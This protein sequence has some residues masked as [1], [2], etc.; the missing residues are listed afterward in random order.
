MGGVKKDRG[1]VI[2]MLADRG[3]IE[4]T[5]PSQPTVCVISIS[6]MVMG[7]LACWYHLGPGTTTRLSF[8]NFCSGEEAWIFWGVG[9][10]RDSHIYMYITVYIV[11]AHDYYE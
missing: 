7:L 5:A 9:G 6:S 2:S 8:R 1:V 3:V 4:V 10:G 11:L